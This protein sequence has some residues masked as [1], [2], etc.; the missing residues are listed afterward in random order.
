MISTAPDD[1]PTMGLRFRENDFS[2]YEA[3]EAIMMPA[4]LHRKKNPPP[5]LRLEDGSHHGDPQQNVWLIDY[6]PRFSR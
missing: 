3:F 2:P 6:H 4:I 5:N 1:M